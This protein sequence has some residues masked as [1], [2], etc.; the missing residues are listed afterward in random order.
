MKSYILAVAV[1]M[2]LSALFAFQNIA[3]VTVRFLVFEWT[4]PQGVWEVFIFCAGAVIMWIFSIFAMFE[5]RGKY[6][7]EIRA[8]DERITAAENEK[9][10]L[11]ETLASAKSNMEYT[12]DPQSGVE[13]NKTGMAD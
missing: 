6:K 2:F 7:R 11:L 9:K 12:V 10:M 13:Q 3:D 1:T 5:A 4:F 8:K